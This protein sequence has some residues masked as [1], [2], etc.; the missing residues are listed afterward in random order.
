MVLKKKKRLEG[1]EMRRQRLILRLLSSAKYR[2]AGPGRVRNS[3][4]PVQNLTFA[5]YNIM[6]NLI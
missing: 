1:Y 4:F 6:E 5:I 3:A 2:S